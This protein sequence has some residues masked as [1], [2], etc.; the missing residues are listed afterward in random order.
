MGVKKAP[1]QW[2]ER[3]EFKSQGKK[4]LSTKGP[5]QMPGGW[6]GCSGEAPEQNR[7]G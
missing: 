7:L 2:L 1:F 3:R 4:R 5:Y 6:G